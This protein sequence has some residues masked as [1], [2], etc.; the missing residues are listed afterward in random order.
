MLLNQNKLQI[1]KKKKKKKFVFP[2]RRE[3]LR[4]VL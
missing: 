4:Y 2:F 3:L 1:N